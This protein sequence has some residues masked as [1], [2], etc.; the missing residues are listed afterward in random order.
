V[1]IGDA[2]DSPLG[3]D[4][5]LMIGVERDGAVRVRQGQTLETLPDTLRRAPLPNDIGSNEM[6]V[7][8]T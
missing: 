5:G 1:K 3:V 7:P 4:I 6:R 2:F 8:T